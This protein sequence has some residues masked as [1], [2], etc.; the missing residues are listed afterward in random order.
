MTE[1]ESK[2]A[3][4]SQDSERAAFQSVSVEYNSRS[5]IFNPNYGDGIKGIDELVAAV[6]AREDVSIFACSDRIKP[7]H[8]LAL[9]KF[10]GEY[11]NIKLTPVL[12][13]N[14]TL[15]DSFPWTIQRVF[16][17]TKFYEDVKAYRQRFKGKIL[18]ILPAS[19]DNLN[20]CLGDIPTGLNYPQLICGSYF[21]CLV[22]HSV[23]Y[24]PHKT[25]YLIDLLASGEACL[26]IAPEH[27]YYY[28]WG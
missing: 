19:T 16:R 22:V 7:G 1:I 14:R 17:K 12:W 15:K 2:S 28:P 18:F 20:P 6:R 13:T 24:W 10:L 8:W 25:L 21:D 26:C 4:F 3:L 27:M 11:A 23:K 9:I 5:Y